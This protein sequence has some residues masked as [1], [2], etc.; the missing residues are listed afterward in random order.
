MYR[1]SNENNPNAGTQFGD[2][3]V[4]GT[5]SESGSE[6]SSG[7]GSTQSNVV[8]TSWGTSGSNSG[9]T[10]VRSDASARGVGTYTLNNS[11]GNGSVS[12]S[13]EK[14]SFSET[15]LKTVTPATGA[16]TTT[17]S[18]NTSGS[19]M[20]DF[21]FQLQNG[22]ETRNGINYDWYVYLYDRET[23][24][25]DAELTLN[26]EGIWGFT[27]GSATSTWTAGVGNSEIGSGVIT[28][29]SA[30]T[31]TDGEAWSYSE[32]RNVIRDNHG[33]NNGEG[34]FESFQV[35]N[36]AWILSNSGQV[37]AGQTYS[38]SEVSV[39]GSYVHGT[40]SGTYSGSN[41]ARYDRS[42]A[43][44]I[45]DA[46]GGASGSVHVRFNAASRGDFSGRHS[47]RQCVGI[48]QR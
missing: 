37:N 39:S 8:G 23:S 22:A 28:S 2:W 16:A 44:N 24:E 33:F 9:T 19:S 20:T 10:A 7:S 13:S 40:I 4:N 14:H 27:S 36:G 15:T 34:D 32:T 21:Q 26:T 31:N 11:N 47:L 5:K 48:R 42:W 6:D 46:A 17:G 12:G 25:S 30:G 38:D 43:R 35:Q 45:G 18:A 1:T 3:E 41:A 29:S